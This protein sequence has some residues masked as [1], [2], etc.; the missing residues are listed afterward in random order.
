[1]IAAVGGG[2]ADAARRHLAGS[3]AHVA[4][5]SIADRGLAA[6]CVHAVG[7]RAL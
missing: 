4:A 3:D 7:I 2:S 1:L 5:T 6:A